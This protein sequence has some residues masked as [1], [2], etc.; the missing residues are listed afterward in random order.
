MF[1]NVEGFSIPNSAAL[2]GFVVIVAEPIPASFALDK[3]YLA[4]PEAG[5]LC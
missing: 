1:Y 5:L 4:R 2:F 3:H